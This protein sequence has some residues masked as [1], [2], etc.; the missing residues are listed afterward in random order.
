MI[1][2]QAVLTEDVITATDT[3]YTGTVVVRNEPV[4]TSWIRTQD[5]SC[6]ED[7]LFRG[8]VLVANV[9]I[10]THEPEVVNLTNKRV[11]AVHGAGKCVT[12]N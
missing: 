6:S 10:F 1:V 2:L 9:L 7:G 12:K 3:H 5:T 4:A 11:K 8:P